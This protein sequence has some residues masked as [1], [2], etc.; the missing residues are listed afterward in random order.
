MN[1][2]RGKPN[3]VDIVYF[4]TPKAFK[5]FLKRLFTKLDYNWNKM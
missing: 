5:K 3:Q 4:N 2:Y 1:K